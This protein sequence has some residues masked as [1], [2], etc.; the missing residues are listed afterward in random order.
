[1]A[2]VMWDAVGERKF[3][4]GV[5]RGVLYPSFDFGVGWSGLVE[6]S[7]TADD[8]NETITYFD[9]EVLSNRLA[10]SSFAATIEAITYPVEFEPFDG[11]DEI[12]GGQERQTFHFSYRTMLGTDIS[13]DGYRLHLVYNALAKPTARNYSSIDPSNSVMALSWD[14]STTPVPFYNSPLSK[15]P[16]RASAHIF[17]DSTTVNPEILAEIEHILYGDDLIDPRIPSASE[18][19]DIF[20]P[21]EVFKI[22]DHGDGTFTAIG[23]DDMV[24]LTSPTEFV[25]SSPSVV[26]VSSDTYKASSY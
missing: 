13:T 12:V 22:I 8:L 2:R 3:E 19:L 4:A 20:E 25:L 1:M 16:P 5:D 24:Y 23:P 17:M 21:Y 11:F 14:I 7:E 10:L 18:I 26:M 9:G 6:V 15:Y